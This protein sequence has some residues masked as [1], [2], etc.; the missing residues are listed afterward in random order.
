MIKMSG[1]ENNGLALWLSAAVS[2]TPFLSTFVPVF[3]VDRFGRRKLLLTSISGTFLGLLLLTVTFYFEATISPLV[4]EARN[5]GNSCFAADTCNNCLYN[6][7]C[8][9]CFLQQGTAIKNAS[10]VP[11]ES[12]SS[13]T[14]RY[15]DPDFELLKSYGC[16]SSPV[17]NVFTVIGLM[18][19]LACFF[20]GLGPVSHVVAS[21]IFPLWARSA[22]LAVATGTHFATK[23][24]ISMT[25]LHVTKLITKAGWFVLLAG[26]TLLAGIFTYFFVPETKGKRLEHMREV[27]LKSDNEPE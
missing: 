14:S 19:F 21:E 16:P 12:Y 18:M 13:T 1:V 24:L 20:A 27:F 2:F 22:G 9:F 5:S 10:C 23:L 6:D 17:I 3:T 25:F 15:C 7:M 26:F 11:L 4:T 8:G